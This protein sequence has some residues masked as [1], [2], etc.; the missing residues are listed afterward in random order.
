MSRPRFGVHATPGWSARG[1]HS[2][3]LIVPCFFAA[4]GGEGLR[5]ELDE[6]LLGFAARL[7]RSRSPAHVVPVRLHVPGGRVVTFI[8]AEDAF[9]FSLNGWISDGR[10]GFHATVEVPAHPV[11]R[12]EVKLRMSGVL[13][14]VNAAVFKKPAQ[15]TKDPDSRG[16]TRHPGP[17]A[18]QAAHAE[19]DGNARP[20]RFV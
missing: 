7:A 18:A 10:H 3:I 6:K 2:L 13:E 1:G 4:R 16:E 14:A 5:S 15:D 8:H 17:Q 20:A 9:Q 11:R 12:T 19:R